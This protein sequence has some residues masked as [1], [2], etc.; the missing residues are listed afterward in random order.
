MGPDEPALSERPAV[1][2]SAAAGVRPATYF[3]G[4]APLDRWSR[5][6]RDAHRED[7]RIPVRSSLSYVWTHRP[8]HA[9]VL[10]E[11]CEAGQVA[12]GK[13]ELV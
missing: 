2:T 3:L 7:A 4:A 1:D 10:A 6:C 12:D 11:S 9:E 5:W 8:R 13:D